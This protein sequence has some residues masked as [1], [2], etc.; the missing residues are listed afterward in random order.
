[1]QGLLSVQ[2]D[3]SLRPRFSVHSLWHLSEAGPGMMKFHAS[4][5]VGLHLPDRKVALGAMVGLALPLLLGEVYGDAVVV[6]LGQVRHVDGLGAPAQLGMVPGLH[7]AEED[8]E[9]E[10]GPDAQDDGPGQ[11][12][13]H[14]RVQEVQDQLPLTELALALIA[15][16]KQTSQRLQ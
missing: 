5:R 1:M 8:R 7:D 11:V 16:N 2:L 14:R 10:D 9:E 12:L 4:T 15:L 6:T 13:H 3:L